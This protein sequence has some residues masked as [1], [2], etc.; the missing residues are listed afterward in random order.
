MMKALRE[1]RQE[2]RGSGA[3]MSGGRQL[4]Q[5]FCRQ[6][7]IAYIPDGEYKKTQVELRCL[8]RRGRCKS[9]KRTTM[10]GRTLQWETLF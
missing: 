1:E 2:L 5:P 3:C 9:N 6:N 7:N 4:Y 8:Q 10:Y